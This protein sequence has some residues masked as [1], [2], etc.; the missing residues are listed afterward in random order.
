MNEPRLPALLCA[1]VV[2][3]NSARVQT[4]PAPGASSAEPSKVADSP[5]I[6]ETALTQIDFRHVIISAKDK[7]FPAVVFI[8]CITE[9]HQGGRK[10]TQEATASGVLISPN[11]EVLTN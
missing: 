11:G 6:S 9:N 2:V 3:F 4:P 5:G 7:V 1:I 10:V 8:K